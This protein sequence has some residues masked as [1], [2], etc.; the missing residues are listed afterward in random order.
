MDECEKQEKMAF[1]MGNE[2]NGVSNE[3]I[4]ICNGSIYIP[5]NQIESLNVG[6]ASAIIMYHFK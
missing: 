1:V 6:I 5:I 3:I 4:D 2:G